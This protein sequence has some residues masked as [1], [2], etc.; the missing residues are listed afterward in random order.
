MKIYLENQL[1]AY[2][3][4]FRYEEGRTECN[5]ER[6][7]PADVSGPKITFVGQSV[8][9]KGDQFYKALGRKIAFKR[10]LEVA[11]FSRETRR[12]F[13]RAYMAEINLPI[14]RRN[15]FPSGLSK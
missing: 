5:I 13:W 7:Q 1:L 3:V 2:S 8:C 11:S 14:Q 6:I 10:A 12:V 9:H 15:P 4:W